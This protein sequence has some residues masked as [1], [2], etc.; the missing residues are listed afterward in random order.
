MR[1]KY[2][3]QK[4]VHKVCRINYTSARKMA[5]I[6]EIERRKHEATVAE[7]RTILQEERQQINVF[8]KDMRKILNDM[9]IES[10]N[11]TSSQIHVISV[12]NCFFT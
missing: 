12:P 5:A 1:A 2:S 9:P 11:T 8:L 4:S 6:V 7:L 10:F 3:N